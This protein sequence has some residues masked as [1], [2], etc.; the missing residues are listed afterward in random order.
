[1]VGRGGG[2]YYKDKEIIVFSC[3]EF[4]NSLG[5]IK[6]INDYDTSNKNKIVKDTILIIKLYNSEFLP[7]IRYHVKLFL[8]SHN[9]HEIRKIAILYCKCKVIS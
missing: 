6:V 1:M 5:I 7:C 8:T 2:I 3:W 9:K 4:Q